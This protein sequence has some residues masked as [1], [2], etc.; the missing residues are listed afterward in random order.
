MAGVQTPRS[1][2]E[3]RVDAAFTGREAELAFFR[4]QL[5]QDSGDFPLINIHGV[6]GTG[7][8]FLLRRFLQI[9]RGRGVPTVKVQFD[10]KDGEGS[11]P[12]GQHHEILRHI[13]L[14]LGVPS[15]RFATA[16]LAWSLSK[17]FDR[18]D[19]SVVG[20]E[21]RGVIQSG[22]EEIINFLVTATLG[23]GGLLV[24]AARAGWRFVAERVSTEPLTAFHRTP[25]GR[26]F[27]QELGAV[28]TD[29]LPSKLGLYLAHDL[30]EYLPPGHV[31]A[32]I[33]F[34]SWEQ[35]E[36][37]FLERRSRW[38]QEEQVVTFF[39]ACRGYIQFV[40]VGQRPISWN[41]EAPRLKVG[42][43]YVHLP[44]SGLQRND[45]ETY[46]RERRSID[47]TLWVEALLDISCESGLGQSTQ[48]HALTLGIVADTAAAIL[49]ADPGA[50]PASL[51]VGP[52]DLEA[53]V[54]RFMAVREDQE[55]LFERLALTPRC[56]AIGLAAALGKPYDEFNALSD[57]DAMLRYSFMQTT[58]EG[59][60]SMHGLMRRMIRERIERYR[61][62]KLRAAHSA[63]R[64]HYQ[65]RG[66]DALAFRHALALDPETTLDAWH[67][68]LQQHLSAGRAQ[69][70]V[71]LM[72]WGAEAEDERPYLP[73]P[74]AA[75]LSLLRAWAYREC[76][77][78]D[79][80]ENLTLALNMTDRADPGG[81][82]IFASE[83][84]LER[85]TIYL[86]MG[87]LV[88][89]DCD[90]YERAIEVLDRALRALDPNSDLWFRVIAQRIRS[91]VIWG[92][93][94]ANQ[95]LLQR[96]VQEGESAVEMLPV[97]A[98]KATRH[99]LTHCLIDS[100]GA[101][102]L[103]Q[104]DVACF[105]RVVS[106]AQSM[107]E[108]LNPNSELTQW[109]EANSQI[110]HAYR[111]WA[112]YVPGTRELVL[113]VEHQRRALE[114]FARSDLPTVYAEVRR[115][116]A[117]SLVEIG[118]RS[119]DTDALSEAVTICRDELEHVSRD[120]NSL[121]WSSLH[122][123]MAKAL[124]LWGE[125]TADR[126]LFAQSA[127]AYRNA[128]QVR[129]R[130]ATPFMWALGCLNLADALRLWHRIEPLPDLL[131]EAEVRYLNALDVFSE[132]NFPAFFA[133]ARDGLAE[134]RQM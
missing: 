11:V 116:I 74:H 52:G 109:L 71:A 13:A 130:R 111:D 24:S 39:E 63:W 35:Y 55:P 40:I 128:L 29:Q 127:T 21:V 125:R 38:F 18:S 91:L 57:M 33:A 16:Y 92:R 122:G 25:E 77:L 10:G 94:S 107:L 54:R 30:A 129:S 4:D 43:D 113:S 34:D 84:L 97:D 99:H 19:V 27:A 124:C 62:D 81:D 58:S 131:S 14:G 108:S 134:V 59:W 60:I 72:A 82:K 83:V 126:E 103:V 64:R 133:F 73:A 85:G 68:D 118:R 3:D 67:A 49:A 50:S 120:D 53:L 110:S 104:G 70:F 12:L 26:A 51:E 132:D 75:R 121:L 17:Q 96:A 20:D 23:P 8:S 79:L 47:S 115:N 98:P 9:A 5:A 2:F 28:P 46:L 32:L 48:H 86:E 76:P 69:Q 61:P 102:G 1:D 95:S 112:D 44:L 93:R 36:E 37:Q 123:N 100:I 6:T 105:E 7:K 101:L 78:G 56:D 117:H 89:E 42:A 90:H 22:S 31:R 65:E 66:L 114:V 41:A 80:R 87:G 15:P 88:W 45:A 106:L 119:E